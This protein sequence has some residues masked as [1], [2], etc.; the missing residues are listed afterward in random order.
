MSNII[1]IIPAF[2]RLIFFDPSIIFKDSKEYKMLIH[3]HI[4]SCGFSSFSFW[5]D[6]DA[7]F[8]HLTFKFNL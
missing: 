3:I 4:L 8:S 2:C 1:M 5:Y 6:V 7:T